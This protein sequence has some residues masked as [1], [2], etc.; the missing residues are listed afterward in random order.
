M[1]IVTDVELLVAVIAWIAFAIRVIRSCEAA[2]Q[3]E[4]TY[5]Q[6]A[7]F[8]KAT[9]YLWMVVAL[10]LAAL[11]DSLPHKI[12]IAIMLVTLILQ[13]RADAAY[14]IVWEELTIP[15]LLVCG[16]CAIAAG[17]T[18]VALTGFSLGGILIAVAYYGTNGKGIGFPDIGITALVGMTVGYFC[19]AIVM[20]ATLLY[21]C[22]CLIR[23][24][25]R[26]TALPY[27]TILAPAAF[28]ASAVVLLLPRAG[29]PILPGMV[30][31]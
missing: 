14:G 2:Y 10:L 20:A 3:S 19:L 29:Y 28:L 18:E 8:G 25:S 7:T 1:A 16:I 23:G 12:A 30:R 17:T 27:A 11:A 31:L 22:L 24:A 6:A 26:K 5:V 13:S 9:T 21:A 15:A 4:V